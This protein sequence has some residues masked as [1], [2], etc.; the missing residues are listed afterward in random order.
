MSVWVGGGT[1]KTNC[2]SAMLKHITPVGIIIKAEK[3]EECSCM[4]SVYRYPKM[5]G[6]TDVVVL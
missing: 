5:T 3:L 4:H 1:V 2:P 6:S